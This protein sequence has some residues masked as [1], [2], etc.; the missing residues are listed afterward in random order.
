LTKCPSS[1]CSIIV[2]ETLV[3]NLVDK[4]SKEKYEK[5]LTRSFI[6]DNPHVK[7]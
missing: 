1:K 4:N 7:W 3:S 2:D 6:D 5:Y